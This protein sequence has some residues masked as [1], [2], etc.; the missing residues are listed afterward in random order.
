MLIILAKKTDCPAILDLLK[1]CAM[2][3]QQQDIYQ[4]NDQYPSLAIIE[5][6]IQ[7]GQLYLLKSDKKII[8]T[9]VLSA[10]KDE[11]YNAIHW[12]NEHHKALYIHRLAVDP[13]EQG[14]GHAQKLMDFAENYARTHQYDSIRLDTFSQNERNQRFYSKRGYEHRGEIYLPAQSNAPFYCLEKQHLNAS[15][16]LS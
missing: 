12:K 1:C 2:E 5:K 15:N 14:K 4:W 8:G 3:L 13:Q 6:D 16:P 9:I 10:L 7:L 11:E